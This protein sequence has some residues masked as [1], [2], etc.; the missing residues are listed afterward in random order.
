MPSKA[1]RKFESRLVSD[2]KSLVDTHKELNGPDPGKRGFGHLTRAGVVMLCAAWEIYLE[3]LVREC[4]SFYCD[5][6]ISPRKLPKTPA[7]E[8]SNYVKN[9]KHE[10]KPLELAGDGWKNVFQSL[11]EAT[12]ASFNTPK[13]TVADQLFRKLAGI[14]KVS[15]SWTVTAA[16]VDNFVT[17][18]G[19]IAHKGSE[20]PYV[21]IDVLQTDLSHIEKSVRD[22]DNELAE[23]IKETTP[24]GKSPWRKRR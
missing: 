2:V 1:L 18:R 9:H 15:E 23:H 3:E 8:I 7:K 5:R 24:Q 12:I 4:V 13:S 22:T 14:E 6:V 19:E 21:R 17:R 11:C 20:A 16:E 10:L